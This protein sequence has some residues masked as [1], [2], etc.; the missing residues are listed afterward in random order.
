MSLATVLGALGVLLLCLR[1]SF[2]AVNALDADIR[3][4]YSAWKNYLK[5]L[6]EEERKKA[7]KR[8]KKEKSHPKKL[9]PAVSRWAVFLF[10][11]VCAA[12]AAL[13]SL[14][15][16]AAIFVI[17]LSILAL[18]FA[19]WAVTTQVENDNQMRVIMNFAFGPALLLAVSLAYLG[20]TA[21]TGWKWLLIGIIIAGVSFLLIYLF[22]RLAYKS[23]NRSDDDE[24]DDEDDDDYDEYSAP[25]LSDSD[26]DD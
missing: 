22:G 8:E 11:L 21:A 7:L 9:S 26:P 18:L 14:S 6:S 2:S 3:E 20:G 16:G 23:R 17:I 24:D 5:S 25:D 19:V 13:A 4:N 15:N 12:L 1:T 10:S